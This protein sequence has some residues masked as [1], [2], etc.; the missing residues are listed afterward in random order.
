M[1]PDMFPDSCLLPPP[2]GGLGMRL[3]LVDDVIVDA[4]LHSCMHSVVQNTH[5]LPLVQCSS[6]HPLT[7]SRHGDTWHERDEW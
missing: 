5:R 3:E 1:Q 4:N 7:I 6:C 2:H